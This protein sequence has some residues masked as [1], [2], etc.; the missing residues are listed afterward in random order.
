MANPLLDEY[1]SDGQTLQRPLN[2]WF[3]VLRVDIFKYKQQSKTTNRM[4]CTGY[5]FVNHSLGGN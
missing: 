4:K 1:T 5:L 2:A 3:Y